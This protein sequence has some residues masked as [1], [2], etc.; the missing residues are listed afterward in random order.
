M[1]VALQQWAVIISVSIFIVRWLAESCCRST[2]KTDEWQF[3]NLHLFPCLLLKENTFKEGKQNIQSKTCK[4]E[5]FWD[6]FSKALLSFKGR[7]LGLQ[8]QTLCPGCWMEYQA[9]LRREWDAS[10]LIDYRGDSDV[11]PWNNVQK[12]Q[13]AERAKHN[14]WMLECARGLLHNTVAGAHIDR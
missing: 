14:L 5:E 12:A 1:Q 10:Y 3:M 9:G 6:L 2:R 4:S 13:N 11:W 8:R 7:A